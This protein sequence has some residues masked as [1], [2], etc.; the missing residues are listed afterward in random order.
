MTA[1][2]GHRLRF[3]TAWS[4]ALLAAASI[5]TSNAHAEG[6]SA[7]PPWCDTPHS[8]DARA[9]LLLATMSQ[10]D[11]IGVLTGKGESDVGTP[12]TPPAGRTVEAYG[13]DPFLSG[14]TAVG[15]IDGF[16]SQG[17][18]ADAKHFAANNQEGQYGVSPLF[19]VY[20]SRPFV[21]VHVDP[22]A[23][24]E[25]EL[26]PFEA[27]ITQGHSATVM[28]SYNLLEGQYACANPFLLKDTFRGLFGS[29]GFVVSDFLACHE[30]EVDLNAGLNFDIGP[31][32]YNAPQVEAALAD[33]SVTQ[34]TFEARVY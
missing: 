8:P 27:A 14:Q 31:S 9:T 24:H 21:N 30:T 10:A 3:V 13:E 17:V 32:C 29:D 11:R 15:W 12:P 25:I 2:R 18:R 7:S 20:G 28:C 5:L 33:G 26:T 16:Q 19:G 1:R 23:L 6:R 34:A 4:L 22:R